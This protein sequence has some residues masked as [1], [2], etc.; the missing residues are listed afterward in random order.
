[1]ELFSESFT[2][3]DFLSHE[4]LAILAK[5]KELDN[6]ILKAAPEWPL[7][8]LNR[9]DLAILR[10]SVYELKFSKIPPKVAIDEAIEIAK[11]LGGENSSS[12]VNGVLGTIYKEYENN[13]Q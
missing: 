11:E 8:K 7:E 2:H 10:Y 3:Q 12:F 5:L 1:M 6:L 13:E 9:I 4:T